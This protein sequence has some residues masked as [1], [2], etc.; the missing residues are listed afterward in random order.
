MLVNINIFSAIGKYLNYNSHCTEFNEYH[1]SQLLGRY[2]AFSFSNEISLN[3]KFNCE[4]IRE[5]YV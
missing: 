5:L 4:Y 1:T 2:T 3:N